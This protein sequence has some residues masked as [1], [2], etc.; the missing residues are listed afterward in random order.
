[1]N[2]AFVWGTLLIAGLTASA[3]EVS[4]TP[5]AEVGVDYTYIRVN[6]GGSLGSFNQNGGS[7]YAEYNFN[8]VFGLVADL[9]GSYVGTANGYSLDNTSF[10]Y[11]FGPRFNLR[12]SRY[13]FYVQTLVGGERL[14][15]GFNPGGISPLLGNS[16][17]DFAA[18]IGGGVDIA[19]TNHIAIKPIQ[20]EYLLS[21]ITPGAGLNFAQ[22]NLRYSAGVVFRFGSK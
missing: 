11:L 1:M 7:A 21:E 22:N 17:N 4:E 8:R 9:G 20:V 16:Q 14:S 5:R 18:A 12:R 19:L 10:T 13:T 2:K 15:Y 3:Q 6:P